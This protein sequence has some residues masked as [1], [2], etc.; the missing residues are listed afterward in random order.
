LCASPLLTDMSRERKLTTI[1]LP[2]RDDLL[3]R[4][5]VQVI[6]SKTV[7]DWTF[8]DGFEADVILC[9]P[10]SNL[11]GVALRRVG[12]SATLACVSV[13]H[14]GQAPLPDTKT[15]RAPIKSAELIA[16]LNDIS[17][18]AG[19][20]SRG[21]TQAAETNDDRSVADV[22]H[23]LMQAKSPDLHAVESATAALFITPASRTLHAAA[24][25]TEADMQ[26]WLGAGRVRTRRIDRQTVHHT[27][28]K[29]S[30]D[31]L[32]WKIGLTH[33]DS[34][35]L[36][37]LPEGAKF[38]LKRW[39]DFGVFAHEMFHF[40]MAALLS[41]GGHTVEGLAAATSRTANEARAFVNACAM[42]D[43]LRVDATP[44]AE[45]QKTTAPSSQRRYSSILKS[46]RS[47][48]GL[49]A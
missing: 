33:T 43:L 37:G 38:K 8:H 27:E 44:A 18:P 5:L 17:R 46:I 29:H 34:R 2:L 13:V 1:G 4:S 35:L 49:H 31:K 24:P 30:F 39:P 48:L 20:D 19:P 3:I 14:D 26:Q 21:P 41:R 15:L 10:D 42:C 45:P 23:E 9:D 36:R 47:A 12:Q 40:R 7:D 25:L 32:L 11:S 28:S 16:L 22:L 6:R